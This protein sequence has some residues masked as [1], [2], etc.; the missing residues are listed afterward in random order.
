MCIFQLLQIWKPK[1]LSCG[2][3]KMLTILVAIPKTNK[4]VLKNVFRVSVLGNEFR[5]YV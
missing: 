2:W 1:Q 4:K 3:S 5:E